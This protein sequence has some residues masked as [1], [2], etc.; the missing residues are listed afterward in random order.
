M[1]RSMGWTLAGLVAGIAASFGLTRLLAG[2]LFGVR[3]MDPLVLGTAAVLVAGV[4]LA[5]SYIPA[6]HAA[7]VDPVTALRCE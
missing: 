6:R 5:A 1:K 7:R 4:A 3:P 2:L